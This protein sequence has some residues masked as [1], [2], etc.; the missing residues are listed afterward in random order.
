VQ[1]SVSFAL[2]S[3]S[4]V[5]RFTLDIIHRTSCL[6]NCKTI[7][8]VLLHISDRLVVDIDMKTAS[9]AVMFCKS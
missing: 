6:H 8:A 7:F 9:L 3:A 2:A 5:D 1:P 4:D